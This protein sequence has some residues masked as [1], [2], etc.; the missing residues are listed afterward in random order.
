VFAKR[1]A[2]ERLAIALIV[3]REKY[4]DDT[5]NPNVAMTISRADLADITGIAEENVTR[6]LK[7]FKDESLLIREGRKIVVTDIKGLVKRANYR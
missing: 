1:N 3:L 6:L 2:A 7:E 4:K 5:V